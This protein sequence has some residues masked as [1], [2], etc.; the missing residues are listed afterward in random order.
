MYKLMILFK[1]PQDVES[2][3][4][5]YYDQFIPRVMNIEGLERIEFASIS[6]IDGIEIEP[7][8]SAPFELQIE[9]YFQARKHFQNFLANSNLGRDFAD[10]LA[11]YNDA[12]YTIT[13]GQPEIISKP[14]IVAR[15]N[16]QMI[17]YHSN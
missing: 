11:Q 5:F 8:E 10:K 6:N 2:F 3:H 1:K 12:I 9:M 7:D 4:Q 17:H 14:E 16:E 15:F 13:W